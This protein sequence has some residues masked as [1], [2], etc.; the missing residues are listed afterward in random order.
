MIRSGFGIIKVKAIFSPTDPSF[1][2]LGD[3][4]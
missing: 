1:S 2:A 3:A 4:I